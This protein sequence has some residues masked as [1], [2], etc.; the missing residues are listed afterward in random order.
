MRAH[1]NKGSHRVEVIG[2]CRFSYPALGGF[3]VDFETI[4]EKRAYLYAPDRMET[5]LRTFEAI[6]LPALKA[7]T[8]PD[9][10][11]LVVI[12]DCLPPHYHDR[13]MALLADVPQA[14]VQAH[15]PGKHRVVMRAAINSVR[16][17]DDQPSLQFRMDDD[18]AVATS[19][20]ARLRQV[21]GEI[22]ELAW[23][24]P[25]VGID[26]NR[27]F[28]VRPGPDGLHAAP[29]QTPY[30]T[31]ALGIMIQ[32]EENHCVLNF[33]HN[34]LAQIMTTVTLTDE[35][36]LVRGHNDHNDSRQKPW[37]KP[38]DLTPLDAEGEALFR[39]TFNIDADAVR[40]IFSR[41]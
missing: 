26:F 21:A 19:F 32:P 37:I 17:F 38:A 3:Q 27:G 35:N 23:R 4:E 1:V 29:T 10:V 40:R 28:I 18:D 25:Y 36:M 8:D 6:T 22:K 12:G 13:L 2:L 33:T 5:R 9:F 16:R 41:P 11:L 14:V 34:R 31:A 7:Q 39:E 24:Y 15:P 30:T 20:V